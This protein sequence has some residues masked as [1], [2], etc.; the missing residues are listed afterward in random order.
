MRH[1]ELRRAEPRFRGFATVF[2]LVSLCVMVADTTPAWSSD[3]FRR[4]NY[5]YTLAAS[6][7]AFTYSG[8][9]L[10]ASC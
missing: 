7:V 6:V 5:R 2:C 9:R 8:S 10:S 4:Y 3:F 1:T